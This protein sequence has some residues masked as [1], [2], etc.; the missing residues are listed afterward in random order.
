MIAGSPAKTRFNPAHTVA[1]PC[2]ILTIFD[3]RISIA[4]LRRR[5]IELQRFFSA[6]VTLKSDDGLPNAQSPEINQILNPVGLAAASAKAGK[7][8]V[9]RGMRSRFNWGLKQNVRHSR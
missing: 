9:P 3:K 5:Q 2:L 1:T 7:S 8:C 6:A 4:I